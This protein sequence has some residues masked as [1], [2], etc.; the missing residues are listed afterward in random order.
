MTLTNRSVAADVVLPHI[1]YQNLSEAIAW[2]SRVFGFTECYR[3]GEG[4]RGAQM[5]AGRAAIQLRQAQGERSP[6]QLGYGIQSLTIFV[7][8]VDEHYARAKA[9]G[10]QILEEPHQTVYG[11]YQYGARDLDGHHWLFSRH[12]RDVNPEEWGAAVAKR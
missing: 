11:E 1:V 9:A 4:P 10:A 3:Y 7:D 2:L 6:A 12:A 5:L 8:D